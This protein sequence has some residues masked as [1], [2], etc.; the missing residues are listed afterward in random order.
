MS[1][2]IVRGGEQMTEIAVC[3]IVPAMAQAEFDRC[4]ALA[5]QERKQKVDSLVLVDKKIQSLTSGLLL[6][7]LQYKNKMPYQSLSHSS[8]YCAAA[9]SD[10]PVGID[11]EQIR[12]VSQALKE[13][14]CTEAELRVL[15][16]S[17]CPDED[18]I[19]FWTLKEAYFKA[20]GGESSL[21][22]MRAACFAAHPPEGYRCSSR[23]LGEHSIISLC[24]KQS[25]LIMR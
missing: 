16:Q 19:R 3:R 22:V 24:E 23:K 8:R 25:E 11:V 14:V 18:F 21:A 2:R 10:M 1:E 13:R 15:Q 17:D 6:Q 9:V 5:N 12:T 7:Y 4:Y 20:R